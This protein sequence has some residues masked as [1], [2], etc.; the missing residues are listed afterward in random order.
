MIASACWQNDYFGSSRAVTHPEAIIG[1]KLLI[2]WGGEDIASSLYNE[3]PSPYNQAS[4]N[5]SRRDKIEKS[6]VEQATYQGIPILGVCRGMQ[7]L[8]ALSG[9]SLYQ[10]VEN[11]E[12]GYHDITYQGTTIQSNSCHHQMVKAFDGEVLASTP[13]LSPTKHTGNSEVETNDPEPEII[14]IPKLR[15]IGVQGHPEWMPRDS[16]FVQLVIKLCQEKL[17][18]KL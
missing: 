10:H 1:A 9:G 11:H 3:I 12:R 6:L 16:D 14:Y 18:V 17:G 5:M 2:L 7:M 15:A 13:C 8:A 4:Y